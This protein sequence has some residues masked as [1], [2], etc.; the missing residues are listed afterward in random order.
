[1]V[2][3]I[4]KEQL[5]PPQ[6]TAKPRQIE[7]LWAGERQFHKDEGS[8]VVSTTSMNIYPNVDGGGT[9]QKQSTLNESP[10]TEMKQEQSIEGMLHIIQ[11]PSFQ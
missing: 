2:P 4:L 7:L 8:K 1:M 5:E 9:N 3:L 11:K 6:G 10:T